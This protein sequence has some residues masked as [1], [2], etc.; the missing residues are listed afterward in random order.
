[1][2]AALKIPLKHIFVV[3]HGES[4]G[5]L[6]QTQYKTVGDD[7]IALT[8]KGER[9]SFVAGQLVAKFA[10]KHDLTIS[11]IDYSTSKRAT[12]TAQNLAVG[13]NAENAVI[14]NQ[15]PRVDK[16]KFGKFDGLFSSKERREAYPEA[17][18]EFKRVE[19][20]GIDGV[21]QARPPEGES[22]VDVIDRVSHYLNHAGKSED[23][24]VVV[25]HGL[26]ALIIEK[27]LLG[28]SN[29]WLVEHF[30]TTENASVLHI[31]QTQDKGFILDEAPSFI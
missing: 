28:R 11:Q 31:Q 9:Q 24:H 4:Q 17:F 18:E 30:D 27:L 19:Q 21:L 3:R 16:Q 5:Q 14:M 6:D 20:S 7:N 29:E 8:Q 25:T 23:T 2:S 10:E 15:E 12:Q 1:M 13:L 26:S 22:I